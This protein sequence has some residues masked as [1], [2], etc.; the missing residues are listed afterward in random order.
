MAA[1]LSSG[2]LERRAADRRFTCL[3]QN[4]VGAVQNLGIVLPVADRLAVMVRG[5]L[6]ALR[7]SVGGHAL[8]P[9]RD[10]QV[11]L[12]ALRAGKRSVRH[13]AGQRVLE[14]ELL[15]AGHDG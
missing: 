4:R 8:D 5:E 13:V 6:C 9:L 11:E 7:S 15:Q 14:A 10:V 3:E 2:G 12:A 1:P